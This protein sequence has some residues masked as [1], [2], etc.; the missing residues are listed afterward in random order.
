[1]DVDEDFNEQGTYWGYRLFDDYEKTY[2][3]LMTQEELVG[4][5]PKDALEII[6]ETGEDWM[7]G[8]ENKGFYFN[9]EF[10]DW[11]TLTTSKDE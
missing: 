1:V 7:I 4:I 2:D 11:E 10:I 3:N 9:G 8:I 5:K 6:K